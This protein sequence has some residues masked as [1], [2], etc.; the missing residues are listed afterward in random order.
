MFDG[1][2]HVTVT[3]SVNAGGN[4]TRFETYPGTYTVNSQ[5]VGSLTMHSGTG[6]V[7]I[8]YDFVL[9]NGGTQILLISTDD[10][11]GITGIATKQ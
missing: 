10:G 1:A 2:G 3:D 4:V 6:G 7:P 9:V 5:G 11:F 8:N